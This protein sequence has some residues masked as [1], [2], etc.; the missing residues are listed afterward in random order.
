MKTFIRFFL[1]L[2]F[3]PLFFGLLSSC[4][5]HEAVDYDIHPGHILCD[6]G[7]L[8]SVDDYL[9]Q[10]HR[11]AVGVVFSERQLDGRYL[12]V[13][14]RDVPPL[15]FCDSDGYVLG[16][17]S[18]LDSLCGYRNTVAMQN[19][20]DTATHHGSP[21]A[22]YV[23]MNH[24]FLQS[25]YIPSVKE[26]MLLFSA[27][28]RVNDIIGR[29]SAADTTLSADYLNTGADS[30]CWYWTSTEVADN[31]GRQAW[32]FSLSSGTYQETSKLLPFH[33]RAVVACQPY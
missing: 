16:T 5:E 20:Y 8:M 26:M 12:A 2:A 1:F 28:H 18:A 13:M 22:D 21:L 15:A 11:F 30:L 17:S 25:D 31:A 23:F 24:T 27:R 14:L 3:M 29:L 7:T 9:S 32:L 19:A 6:D 10:S 4:D 33:S